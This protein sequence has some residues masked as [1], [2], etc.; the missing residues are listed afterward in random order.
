M[1]LVT[2]KDDSDFEVCKASA[3]IISKLKSCLLK[4]KLDEPSL[5][6]ENSATI[7]TVYIKET[8]LLLS[9]SDKESRNASHVIEEI[10]DSNDTNLLAA[11]YK[12]SMNMNGEVV[13]E[14][15]K[16]M[17]DYISS[18]TRQDFLRA[19]FNCDINAYIE[20]KNRWLKTYT[21]SFESILDDILTMYKQKDINSMDCY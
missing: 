12:S 19:I 7:D 18:V 11:I 20:E 17:L 9:P 21:S 3:T 13:K 4:Y 6:A 15:E 1:L 16:K 14:E 10:V 2:L 5:P 8:P